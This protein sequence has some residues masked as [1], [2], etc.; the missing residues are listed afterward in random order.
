MDIKQL[1]EK[2]WIEINNN[3]SDK[4]LVLLAESL[5]EILPHPNGKI[6]DIVF[7]KQSE[8]AIQNSLSHKFGFNSFPLHSDTA[9]WIKPARYVLLTTESISQ[10]ATTIVTLKQITDN[11]NDNDYIDFEQAVYL[12]KVKNR[13]FYTK[14]KQQFETDYCFRYDSLTMKP[15]NKSA[16][17]IEVRLNEILH[18]LNTIKIDWNSNKVVILDNWKTLHGRDAI[19]EDLN[20]KLKRIYIQ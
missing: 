12:I 20:R 18:S 14:L 9:F 7:P 2:G 1:K 8:Q 15:S 10:T 5:G 13:T 17:N 6:I 4:E 16:K 19:Q 11:F 3:L